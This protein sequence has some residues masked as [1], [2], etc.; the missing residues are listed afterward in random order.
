MGAS[1]N[2]Y[3]LY[4]LNSGQTAILNASTNVQNGTQNSIELSGISPAV[5]D[6]LVIFKTTGG[7]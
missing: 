2:D 6:R 4:I 1:P 5:G 7:W 3:D